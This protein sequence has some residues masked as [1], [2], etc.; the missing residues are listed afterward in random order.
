MLVCVSVCVCICVY[1]WCCRCHFLVV[2]I[3]VVVVLVDVL[4]WWLLLPLFG[5][6]KPTIN[7]QWY[8]V[9]KT[10]AFKINSWSSRPNTIKKELLL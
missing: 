4:Q 5:V 8:A 9:S 3:I 10:S 7:N 1:V 2:V 6:S